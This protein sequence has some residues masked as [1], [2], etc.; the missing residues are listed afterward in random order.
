[1]LVSVLSDTYVFSIKL[2][3]DDIG[4]FGKWVFTS[5]KYQHTKCAQETA[6]RQNSR[7]L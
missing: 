3:N 1:M 7:V 5:L 6:G 4:K 2:N